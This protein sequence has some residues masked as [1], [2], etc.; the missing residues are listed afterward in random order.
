[1]IFLDIE[2]NGVFKNYAELDELN[3][4]CIACI[5][6][7]GEVNTFDP[8]RLNDFLYFYEQNKDQTFAAHNMLGFDALV[9]EHV[10]GVRIEHTLDTLLL[11]Q[12]IYPDLMTFDMQ[13]NARN[14][15][16]NLWGSHSL[17]AWGKRIGFHKL[18]HKDFTHYTPEMM[19]YCKRDTILLS[20][21]Y[22][23]L[24]TS[25]RGL[26]SDKAIILEHEFK[27]YT[28]M[29]SLEGAPYNVAKASTLITQ[30][31][32]DFKEIEQWAK[33]HLPYKEIAY[34]KLK[35]PPKIIYFNPTSRDQIG[36]FFVDKYKWTPTYL[37]PKAEKPKI[38]EEI[39]ESLPFEEAKIFAKAFQINK[40]KGFLSTG[41][42]SWSKHYCNYTGRIHGQI[43]T[44]G[45]ATGRCAH[46]SPN[47]GQVP[48]VRAYMGKEV[49]SLFYSGDPNHVLVGCDA[50]SLELRCLAHYLF[51]Y[52]DGEYASLVLDGDVHTYNQKA[53]G[54]DTRDQAK[55]FIY[56]M[57]YGAGNVKLGSI[58]DPTADA[59]KQD[60]L[61]R[62]ARDRFLTKIKGYKI[63]NETIRERLH[64]NGHLR[65]IDGRKIYVDK[66]HT[67][68]N[69]L[70]QSCGA[71]IMKQATILFYERAKDLIK[72][73]LHVH[74]EF[75]VICKEQ[76][77][78]QVGEIAVKSIQD[79]QSVLGFKLRLD[80][81]YK[82]GHTW[83]ATH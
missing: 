38:S 52:D 22:R 46:H 29:Q 32:E 54:L 48:S 33:D 40:L 60:S 51:P 16:K 72:P 61:G 66:K 34:K 28:M 76:D 56:A 55:T 44:L 30:L 77:A 62:G 59:A 83:E 6:E 37:T 73:C 63:L 7:E 9:L 11:S 20:H 79:T 80:G 53:A 15:P 43:N 49:R 27:K 81:E 67:A 5:N 2:T 1:M 58:I 50:S 12:L 35:K 41:S 19:E 36:D 10:M 45:T 65:A 26:P 13:I 24:K 39:L 70:L 14:L 74:D 71:I 78:K 4:L 8:P 17:E 69:Y 23:Y 18:E 25:T 57:I 68:L 47:L 31:N 75:Q 64:F 42:S 3:I 21:L 82:V